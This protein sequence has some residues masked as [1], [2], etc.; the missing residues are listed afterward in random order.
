M[1]N[2]P[3]PATATG[4]EVAKREGDAHCT[5]VESSWPQYISPLNLHSYTACTTS[6]LLYRGTMTSRERHV[7]LVSPQ[8]VDDRLT[9]FS[10]SRINTLPTLRPCRYSEEEIP[11]IASGDGETHVIFLLL[12]WKAE[13][14]ASS[15]HPNAR[16][17]SRFV[18]RIEE[19][20][21]MY[22]RRHLPLFYK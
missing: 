6:M 12:R 2:R 9:N 15:I 18:L 1:P 22:L 16:S 17:R 11:V 13:C 20:Q 8:L 14:P 4:P 19:S 21:Y 7:T 5:D 3:G 10:S